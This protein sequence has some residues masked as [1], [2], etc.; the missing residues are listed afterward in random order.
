MAWSK[1]LTVMQVITRLIEVLSLYNL[2]N[3]SYDGYVKEGATSVRRPKLANLNVKT[4]EGTA[5][6]S[7][8][9]TAVGAGTT[10]VETDLAVYAIPIL[11]E[12]AAQWSSNDKLR[13]EYIVS[14]VLT[15]QRAFD[16]AVI[17]A[18]QATDQVESFAGD[19]MAWGDIVKISQ[20]LNQNEVPKDG[21]VVVISA[22][23]EDQ[24][25]DIDV[26]KNAASYNMQLLA[27]GK[28]I[29]LMGMKFFISGNV[30]KVN[31]KDCIVGFYGQ[32]LAF[33]LS[34]FGEIKEVYSP[35]LLA[36]VIDFLAYAGCELDANEFAVV[37]TTK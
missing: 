4:N 26:V 34:K 30:P 16:K 28:M 35:D 31:G 33:I 8:D 36:D 12:I 9:R 1:P 22:N 11:A 29:E 17:A 14:A 18:A 27:T 37:V 7:G 24:F 32:G 15:L 21:R 6:N 3:R 2:C 20:V 23:L 13:Q 19:K 25:W 5:A 10:M